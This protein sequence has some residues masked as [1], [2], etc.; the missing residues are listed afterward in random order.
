MSIFPY[1]IEE[2]DVSKGKASAHVGSR[3]GTGIGSRI[4]PDEGCSRGSKR[5]L[6]P[7]QSSVQ[8]GRNVHTIALF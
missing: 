7:V 2:W 3:M 1:D 5:G 6:N 8:Y 4:G